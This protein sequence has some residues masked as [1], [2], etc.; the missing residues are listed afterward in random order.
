MKPLKQMTLALAL[1]AAPLTADAGAVVVAA[2][3]GVTALDRSAVQ[4][5]FLGRTKRLGSEDVTL[6]MQ[7]SGAVREAFD[8]DVLGK[9][10]SQLTAHWSRLI[11]TGRAKQPEEANSDAD[12]IAK[13]TSTPG[14][15]GYVTQLPADGSVRAV[16]E[17]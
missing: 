2:E 15:I 1:A 4:A 16:L 10:G 11:F 13:V 12:V 14:A 17:F 3:S 5:L 8:R 9:P 7:K 6:V